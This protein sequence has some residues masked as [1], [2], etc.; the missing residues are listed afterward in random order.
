MVNKLPCQGTRFQTVSKIFEELVPNV[1]VLLN[2]TDLKAHVNVYAQVEQQLRLILPD[3]EAIRQR[4]LE[5]SPTKM[6]YGALTKKK[7]KTFLHQ[8]DLLYAT[9]QDELEPNFSHLHQKRITEEQLALKKHKELEMNQK[10]QE[11]CVR[12]EQ[13]KEEELERQKLIE[14]HKLQKE[15]DLRQ[16]NNA[17]L[18]SQEKK[19]ENKLQ[20]KKFLETFSQALVQLRN[21]GPKEYA[22][23]GLLLYCSKEVSTDC[24]CRV[25]EPLL[26]ILSRVVENPEIQY[27]RVIRCFN[28][29]FYENV[30]IHEGSTKI[31]MAA[32]FTLKQLCQETDYILQAQNSFEKDSD[33]EFLTTSRDADELYW[34]FKEPDPASAFDEWCTLTEN[35]AWVKK[36]L[37][38]TIITA[39]R[40]PSNNS[41]NFFKSTIADLL[42]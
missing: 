11:H 29:S 25:L 41:I 1:E 19:E 38:T 16:L 23:N 31:L 9:Y 4:V 27:Y 28:P 30:G 24:L 18:E 15:N 6:I 3:V 5:T 42:F 32:G 39:R 36:F 2:C 17:L 22:R 7:I 34:I 13:S 37:E 26:S 10:L 12:L 20:Q 21:L 8:F 35:V 40:R 14:Y 33:T